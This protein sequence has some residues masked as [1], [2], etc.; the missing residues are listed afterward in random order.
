M[1]MFWGVRHA[2]TQIIIFNK[3]MYHYLVFSKY[4]RSNWLLFIQILCTEYYDQRHL[5]TAS[6]M[7]VAPKSQ[8]K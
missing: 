7:Q 6:E 4:T 2:N 1:V 8:Q 3:Y 5:K